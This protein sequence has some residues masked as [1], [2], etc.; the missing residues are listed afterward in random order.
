MPDSLA[1]RERF[2]PSVA[3]TTPLISAQRA[4]PTHAYEVLLFSAMVRVGSRGALAPA[5]SG[6]LESPR[7]ICSGTE[8]VL[9][10]RSHPI[11]DEF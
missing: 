5:C 10:S 1:E 9:D 2:E 8:L 6:I 11:D 7:I 4:E 3:P